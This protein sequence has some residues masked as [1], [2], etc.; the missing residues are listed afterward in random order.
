M[1]DFDKNTFLSVLAGIAV[2][3]VIASAYFKQ[4]EPEKET[5]A[6]EE[7]EIK[8]QGSPLKRNFTMNRIKNLRRISQ[9]FTDGLAS[10]GNIAISRV[11]HLAETHDCDVYNSPL[12][13]DVSKRDIVGGISGGFL[14]EEAFSSCKKFILAGRSYMSYADIAKELK[15]LRAG[16]RKEICFKPSEVKA[17][18]VTCGGLCPGMNVVIRE[19]VMSL[20]YNYGVKDIFGVK[21]GYRGFHKDEYMFKIHPKD[22]AGIH[23]KGGTWLGSARG[24]FDA[25]VIV[26]ACKQRGINQLYIIGGD[27][28]HKGIYALYEYITENKDKISVCGIPKTI[29]NDIPIID[30]SFGF[31]TA[32]GVAEKIIEAANCEAESAEN[33]VGLVKVMGRDS[34][35]IAA[36]ST[37]ASRDVNLCLIPESPFEIEGKYGVCETVCKRLEAKGHCVIVV[38][39]GADDAALDLDLKKEAKTDAGGHVKHADIGT[40]LKGKDT[41]LLS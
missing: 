29:D 35:Y 8:E 9:K 25:K 2:G 26:D 28:T 19:L 5:P 36:F 6:I 40:Y 1:S 7:E 15:F 30:K 32:Y 39:E 21:W 16:P 14:P 22:V 27:G 12:L 37:L 38:A 31:D 20:W 24:G 33:G 23:D 11:P 3:A 41:D 18:I 4:S 10:Q 17:A 13:G 34:G